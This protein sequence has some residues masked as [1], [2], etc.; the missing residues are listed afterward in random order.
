[1][2]EKKKPNRNQYWYEYKKKN[3]KR[4]NIIVR[5]DDKDV[6]EK[7]DSVKSVNGYILGLIKEDLKNGKV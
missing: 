4:Y 6:L 5:L 3:Y 1:M 2:T 7:L